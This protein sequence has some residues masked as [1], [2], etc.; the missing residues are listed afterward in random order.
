MIEIQVAGAGAGKTYSLA[1]KIIESY[2]PK[3]QKIIYAVTYTNAAS[4]NI[5]DAIIDQFGY[6]PEK[7]RI[8]TIHTFLLHEI[9]YPYSP[10]VLGERYTTSSR[11]P[12]VSINPYGK[13]KTEQNRN[14]EKKA[15]IKRLKD[16]EI[17]HV[18]E[19][20]AAAWRV[21]D[22]SHTRHSS[23]SKK[24][25]VNRIL[26][27]LSCCIEKI[28]LDEAQDLDST[29]IKVFKEIGEKSVDIYMVGDPKQA[30]KHPD[31]FKDFLSDNKANS[32][33]MILESINTT[34]RVPQNILNIS[35]RFCPKGQEQSSLSER[36]G[37]LRYIT[38]N[39]HGYDDFLNY[40]IQ[41]DNLVSIYQKTGDYST[42]ST[43]SKPEFDP[44]IEKILIERNKEIDTDLLIG[45]A[46]NWFANIISK[47][48]PS[49]SIN[50]FLKE[51][52]ITYDKEI[53]KHLCRTLEEYESSKANGEK[54]NVSSITR[55]KG[56]E[57]DVCILILTP[58]IHRY[59]MQRDVTKYNKTWNMVYVALTRTKSDLIIAIDN[60]LLRDTFT[61][62]EVISDLLSLGF[63]KLE[64]DQS[65]SHRLTTEPTSQV[66]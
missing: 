60:E 36:T 62:D 15:K 33:I 66:S 57:A 50:K 10:F 51:F 47:N 26:K 37:S 34:R 39:D 46:K 12:L 54:Y 40:H 32:K 44:D 65:S 56:L 35:N 59:L 2:D 20:Y 25:K 48:T 16:R 29:A 3:S 55:T 1:K 58:A 17:M 24:E 4:K 28:F 30:I 45:A 13:A 49:D 31:S 52:G 61:P 63:S 21:V 14:I 43:D 23:K 7:I 11:C 42:K 38:S 53:Y 8:Q 18:E 22:E 19:A 41:S 64:L 6:L 5:S 27:I 9:I